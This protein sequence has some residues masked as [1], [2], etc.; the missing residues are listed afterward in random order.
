MPSRKYPTFPGG[1]PRTKKNG[2]PETTGVTP[3]ITS[4]ARNGSPNVP[5]ISRTS[6]R[7]NVAVRDGSTRSPRI[8]TSTGLDGLTGAGSFAVASGLAGGP[9]GASGG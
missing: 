7:D 2:R 5:G 9:D 6:A 8:T 3:G 1:A 4:M